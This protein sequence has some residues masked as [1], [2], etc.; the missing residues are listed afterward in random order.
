MNIDAKTDL[1]QNTS[2][3]NPR[4]HKKKL[5]TTTKLNPKYTIMVQYYNTD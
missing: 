4:M 2:K 5:Y 1:Q 3:S